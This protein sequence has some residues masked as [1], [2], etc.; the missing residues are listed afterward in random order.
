MRRVSP[1]T[2]VEDLTIFKKR[3]VVLDFRNTENGQASEMESAK[4]SNGCSTIAKHLTGFSYFEHMQG[5]KNL[6]ALKTLY[7]SST[8]GYEKLQ[9]FRLIN[10]SVDNSVLQKFINET[11]H[12]EN[13]FICQLDPTK[14]DT[15]P[16]YI[17]LECDRILN[18]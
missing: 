8:N 11:Y 7:H 5:I 14:F 3:D 6:D 16:E 1:D 10:P 15:V 13:E 9:I 4:F 17:V 18:S 12:I 2:A